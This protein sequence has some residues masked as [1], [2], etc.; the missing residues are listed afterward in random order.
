MIPTPEQRFIQ[1]GEAR[2]WSTES[3]TGVPV[4]FFNGGPGCDDYLG[5]VAHLLDE[6]CRVIRFE[7]RGCG[8][9]DWDGNYD[10]DTS[11]GCVDSQGALCRDERSGTYDLANTCRSA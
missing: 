11:L 4:L 10:L 7:P 2:L 1:S 9:S 8:R 3:G 5:P 6:R